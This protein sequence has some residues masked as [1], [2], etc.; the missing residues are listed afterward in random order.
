[1]WA[2]LPI[3]MHL[4]ASFLPNGCNGGALSWRA[5]APALRSP[6]FAGAPLAYPYIP[7]ACVRPHD[8]DARVPCGGAHA[9]T[10]R[11]PLLRGPIV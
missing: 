3:H 7:G 10:T 9:A 1:V 6:L 8:G 2:D 5:G 11:I 4:A